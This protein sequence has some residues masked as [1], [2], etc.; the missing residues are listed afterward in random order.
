M[1]GTQRNKIIVADDDE[2]A[3]ETVRRVIERKFPDLEIELFKDGSSLESR[4]NGEIEN[5]RLVFTDNTM[6]GVTGSE[7]IKR[8]SLNPE[9]RRIPFILHYGGDEDIGKQAVSDGGFGY[10]LKPSSLVTL[11]D[12]INK[13]LSHSEYRP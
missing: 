5:V 8:Y 10:L 6:P 12:M 13:A 9:F 7:L 2:F 3:R 4:L 1:T 11:S